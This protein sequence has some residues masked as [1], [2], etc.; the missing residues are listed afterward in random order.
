[1]K[2]TKNSRQRGSK[3]YGWGAM[4]KHRGAGNKGGRG[5]AGSGKRSDCKKPSVWGIKRFYGNFGFTP[6]KIQNICACN[7]DML[8][9]HYHKLLKEGII[10]EEKGIPTITLDALNIDK[11]LSKGNTKRKWNITAKYASKTAVEKI[12]TAGGTVTMTSA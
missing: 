3:T 6:V 9:Q 4:K 1:M 12:K 5:N 11:L 7:I 10:K 2:R 8:E